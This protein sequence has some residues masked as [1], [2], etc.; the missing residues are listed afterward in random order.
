MAGFG[1]LLRFMVR[2]DRVRGPAWFAGVVGLFAA[3]V[4]SV[5]GLYSTP[6]ELANYAQVATA[7]VAIKAISGPGYGLDD[8]TQGAVVMNE[9]GLFTL[10]GVALMVVFLL[11][12]HTRAEEE[13]DRAELVRAAP[14]GRYAT[15]AAASLWVSAL[16]LAVSLGVTVSLLAFGLPAPGSL[17]YGSTLFLFGLTFIGIAAVA[18]QVAS[19]SRAATA[20]ASGVLGASFVVRAVGDMG[21]GPL[22][23][24]SPLGWAQAIRPYADER[25]WVLILPLVASMVLATA[26]VSFLAKRDL[27]AGFFKQRPGR[28]EGSARLAT[29]LALVMR[30]QR[31]SLIGWTLGV[32]IGGFF[33]G[34]VADQADDLLENEAIAEMLAASGSASPTEQFLAT[35]MLF[36]ALVAS[37]FAVSSALRM[38]REENE[39][40]VAPMLSTPVARSRWMLGYAAFSAG[41]SAVIMTCTG[42]LV[43]LGYGL[44]VGDA[45][46][47]LPLVAAGFAMV[48]ALWVLSAIT[49]ALVGL[50]PKL[51][52]L[53]WAAVAVSAVVGLLA[54]TLKLPQWTRDLSPFQHVPALPGEPFE[55]LPMALLVAVAVGLTA[56]GL[57]G[58]ERR[59]IQ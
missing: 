12:R 11:I 5:V 53:A 6:A 52:S 15:L 20:S 33:F 36:M 57:L 3:S 59:D 48:P 35:I 22:I 8:P 55:V 50:Q 19:S 10:L 25:W 37:G 1:H 46:E 9:T 14:I 56:L 2:R 41:G 32:A 27:G 58:I 16:T 38:R 39:L 44:Q 42:L 30:L 40:R 54:E 18:A 34:M 23:W 7:D 17:A 31:S 21:N 47:V 13:G 28:A 49:L 24:L 43:G 51:A 45:G 26:A 4:G 29:P